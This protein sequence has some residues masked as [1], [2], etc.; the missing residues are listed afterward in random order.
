MPD[1][2]LISARDDVVRLSL[3]R[4]AADYEPEPRSWEVE[5]LDDLLAVAARELV[6]ALDAGRL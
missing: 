4:A 1:A 6:E 3:R 5:Y 2:K